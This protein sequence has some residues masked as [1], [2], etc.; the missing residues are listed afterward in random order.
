MQSAEFNKSR[1]AP[2]SSNAN[3]MDTTPSDA[4]LTSAP[5]ATSDQLI[6]EANDLVRHIIHQCDILRTGWKILE[7]GPTGQN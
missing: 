7:C 6:D 5:A 2:T 1:L 4:P 3:T